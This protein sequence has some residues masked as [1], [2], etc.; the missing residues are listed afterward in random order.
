MQP[1]IQ[2]LKKTVFTEMLNMA[3]RVFLVVRHSDKVRIGDRG[4]TQ[5]EVKNGIVLVLNTKMKFSW[6]DQ[7]ISAALIFGT[8]AEQCYVP[9]DDIMVIY[10]PELNAQFM[11]G[12]H[13]PGAALD[14]NTSMEKEK[15]IK[16]RNGS[17][18]SNVVRVDFQKKKGK[19]PKR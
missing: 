17:D 7:G 18:D 5:D 3:G 8:K 9:S 19:A 10:S 15:P 11:T 13:T 16:S 12:S 2:E 4:F 14:T 6:D 1:S